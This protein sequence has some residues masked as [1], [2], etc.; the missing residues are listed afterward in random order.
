LQNPGLERV[1]EN[2]IP[3][4]RWWAEDNYSPGGEYNPG[5]SFDTPFFSQTDDPARMINGS[6]LQIEATAF[7]NLKVH[8]FQTVSAPP[9]VTVRFQASAKAYSDSGGIKLAAGIDPNGGFDCSQARWGDTL[10]IDQSSGTVQLL[11]PDV[12]VGRAGRVTV[13]LRA[14]NIYPARSN[15][16]F[17]DNAT[18]IANP[19]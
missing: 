4:W 12:V 14:E 11:T 8:I 5:T 2:V 9:T 6:T 13:C 15:A 17:F 10:T 16:A 3:G 19:E 1:Q 18:L 7:V